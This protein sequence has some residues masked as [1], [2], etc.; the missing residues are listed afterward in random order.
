MQSRPGTTAL[1]ALS[2]ATFGAALQTSAATPIDLRTAVNQ[3]MSFS[4]AIR[5][6]EERI[7]Q[8][9]FQKYGIR[10]SIL[11][12]ID[13]TASG[14]HRKDA[15]ANRTVGAVPFGGSP[16]NLYSVGVR[17]EQL[18][19]GY[20]T[21]A[22]ISMAEYDRELGET[23]VEIAKRD[24][25]RRI[26]SVFYRTVLNENLL[27]IF[28]EQ[29]KVVGEILGIARRRM[30][31]GGKRIDVL[32]VQTQLALLKPKIEKAK[33]ELSAS[34]AELANLMGQA[35]NN[36]ITIRGYMPNIVTKDLEKLLNLKEFEL[37]ELNA[38]RLRREQIDK[39]KS[40]TLG[41][42]LPNLKLIGDY[43]FINYTKADLLEP[44]SNSWSMQILLSVPIFSGL[45]SVFERRALN[46]R[47]T[48]LEFQERNVTNAA[49]L[50]QIKSRKSLESAEASL[51]SAEEAAKLAR[52][53][54]NEARREYRF[55]IIDFLQ[56]LQVEAQDFEAATSLL[57]L[58]YDAINA[59]AN[60]F[61]ASG[62]P[63]D[64]LVDLLS[65]ETKKP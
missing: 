43:N 25:T 6:A 10:T 12:Q 21:F 22:A 59:S 49:V 20:G 37:P 44:A 32:Q 15:V 57:Q 8:L 35:E 2:L 29:E 18:L 36:E 9:R 16:Y 64:T 56:F 61:A 45:S 38:I 60:Y 51:A 53:S 1:F 39:E 42:N 65:K 23:Q 50:E 40:V 63:L 33:N 5:E 41:K 17:G 46:S 27:R 11:P 3:S 24:L 4:P 52:E 28:D 54:L 47:D 55:G 19:L 48:Q 7:N 58:R 62:Q 26:I 13:V 34:A 30:N 14:S 31:L